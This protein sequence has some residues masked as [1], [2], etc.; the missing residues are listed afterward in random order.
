[1]SIEEQSTE[2]CGGSKPSS[3]PC[4]RLDR[5]RRILSIRTGSSPASQG[6]GRTGS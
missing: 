6:P 2:F 5:I 4:D 3:E 1:M